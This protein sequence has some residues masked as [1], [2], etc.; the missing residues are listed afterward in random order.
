M[1]VQGMDLTG[2]VIIV[3]DRIYSG[4]RKDRAGLLAEQLLTAAGVDVTR[5][6]I[7]P[8]GPEAV[9]EELGRAVATGIRVIVTV[10]GTGVGPRNRT[11]EATAPLLETELSAV[12]SQI[13]FAGLAN[14]HQ[15]GLSRGLVGLTARESGTGLIVNAPS[16]AGGVSDALGVVCPLLGPIFER[17]Y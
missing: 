6:V 1:P 9:G 3:S 15:A 5:R 2:I 7:I 4:E 10:G 8:E 14:T 11:P 16:S 13:L 17:L 12:M